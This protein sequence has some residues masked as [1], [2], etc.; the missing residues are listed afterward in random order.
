VPTVIA[1]SAISSEVALRVEGQVISKC[2]R[3]QQPL[4]EVLYETLYREQQR[5]SHEASDP[6][7][8]HDQLFFKELRSKLARADAN[9][10]RVLLHMVVEHYVSEISGHFNRR[11]YR[12]A[13]SVLPPTLGALLH[14]GK[15]N[16]RLF[17][18][19]DRILLEGDVEG[20]KQAAR[21][22]TVVLVPT[23]F[24]NLDSLLLGYAI[25]RLGLPPFAYGAG[26]NLFSNALTG[27][28]MKNLGAFTVDRKK[29]DPLYLATVKEYAMVLLEHGQHLLFFPGGT[30]SR[31]GALESQLK[32]GFLSRV[33]GAFESCA[34]REAKGPP[35]FVVPCTLSYPLVLE[36][37]SLID[38]YLSAEGGPHFIDMHDEFE[39]PK[40]W[41]D[42]LNGLAE[43]DLQVHV[44]FG[45][46]LDP[47]G[48]LV[49][50]SGTSRDSAGRA[51][52]PA[53]YLLG[54]GAVAHDDA[55]DTEYTKLL[56]ERV[57]SSYRRDSVALPSSALALALFACLRRRYPGLD[58]FRLL[59]VLGPQASVSF[60]ELEPQLE[61]VLSALE[62]AAQRGEL[63]LS[64]QL[65]AADPRRVLEQGV[66][67]LSAYHREPVLR[68]HEHT[69]QV[70]QPKL[71]VYYQN[72]LHGFD[73]PEARAP[74]SRRH[75]SWSTA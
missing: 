9:A 16:A 5:L 52:D 66:A 45:T 39:R 30:R 74:S 35:L 59:R 34:A 19:D 68:R 50:R 4:E 75:T 46:P 11:V 29:T 57:L 6:R 1:G 43:L 65:H 64:P 73:L 33:I 18:V 58:L 61:L 14:G 48:N 53:R 56:A 15:L 42:F 13:T 27:F 40:S 55:R 41:L 22:G 49:D 17:E 71:L 23:H 7:S 67:T 47:I 72:R 51:L 69:L 24:S 2:Q 20:L 60:A 12:F 37:A 3:V 63:V 25:F 32:L 44:R 54:D 28:F 21:L 36:A 62:A 38:G 8:A 26:L 10:C 70:I 31:S